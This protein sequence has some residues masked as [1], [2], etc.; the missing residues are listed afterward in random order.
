MSATIIIPSIHIDPLLVRC[1][2]RCR[3]LYPDTEIL[4]L[5]DDG[6]GQEQIVDTA[7]VVVTGPISIAEKRNKGAA[8]SNADHLAFIDSDAYPAPGWLEAAEAILAADPALGAVG[9]PN[10]SP[11]EESRSERHVGLAHHSFLVAGWWAYR[12]DPHAHEREVTALPSC[13]LIVRRSEYLAL[14]GMNEQLF[15][16]E[17]TDFCKRFVA[18]GRR[19]WFSPDVLVFHKNRALRGYII[20]RF[21]F[22]VAMAPLL[23]KGTAPDLPYTVV[24]YAIAGFTLFVVS[25]P[26]ALVVPWWGRLWLGVMGAY[27]AVVFVEAIRA[28]RRPRDWP[29]TMVALALGN[30]LPGAGFILKAVHAVPDLRGV[31]RNDR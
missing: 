16:A 13:N 7:T 28:S 29:G 14:G 24:S 17:D 5:V 1:V 2:T 31:Y 27:L 26:L 9:G 4:A 10:V 18:S 21:T 25:A 30:L 20:Q 15:T 6:R 19:I 3:E 23:R 22:G 8:S 12:R 11:P